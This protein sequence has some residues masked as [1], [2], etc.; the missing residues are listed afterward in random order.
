VALALFNLYFV[1]PDTR[2]ALL[3]NNP[4]ALFAENSVLWSQGA[5][6]GILRDDLKEAGLDRQQSAFN[7]WVIALAE[8]GFHLFNPT[9]QTQADHRTAA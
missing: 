4:E 7:A 5:Q 9:D 8:V 2:K 1:D 6:S 3:D